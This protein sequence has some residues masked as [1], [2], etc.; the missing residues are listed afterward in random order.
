MNYYLCKNIIYMKKIGLF[1][2]VLLLMCSCR[3][4]EK[5]VPST[6]TSWAFCETEDPL[7]ELPILREVVLH[8]RET[9]SRDIDYHIYEVKA[10]CNAT[11]EEFYGFMVYQDQHNIP[12]GW[13]GV[14][15][16]CDGNILF[17]V[18]GYVG[19][20][21]GYEILEENLIYTSVPENERHD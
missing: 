12:E 14:C 10:R 18:G 2:A 4:L 16:D 13:S 15:Y 19:Q 7:N 6:Y 21:I 11:G 20:P 17:N 3:E 9:A 1:I 8:S 5:V